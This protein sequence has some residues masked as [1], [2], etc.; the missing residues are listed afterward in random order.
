MNSHRGT[1]SPPHKTSSNL[2]TKD[3]KSVVD[4]GQASPLLAWQNQT[5]RDDPWSGFTVVSSETPQARS[6]D[7]PTKDESD[8]WSTQA[9]VGSDE[10]K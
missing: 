6:Q 5:K 2:T 8:A 10:E 1:T 3:D 7:S 4:K 9:E